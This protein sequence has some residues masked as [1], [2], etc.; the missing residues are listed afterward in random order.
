MP[1]YQKTEKVFE[2]EGTIEETE[3]YK[4][5]VEQLDAQKEQLLPLVLQLQQ[6]REEEQKLLTSLLS[7]ESLER[8]ELLKESTDKLISFRTSTEVSDA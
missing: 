1:V 7:K 6:K 2:E 5:F 3:D 4:N 8:E